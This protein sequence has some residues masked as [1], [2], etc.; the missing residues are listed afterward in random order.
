MHKSRIIPVLIDKIMILCYT[1]AMKND[2]NELWGEREINPF[3]K[4]NIQIVEADISTVRQWWKQMVTLFPYY[5]LYYITHGHARMFL[6]NDT[7]DLHPG[8]IYFIPAFSVVDAEC[9][10]ELEH[11]W[12]HFQL[13]IT[14]TS[15]LAVLKPQYSVPAL[16]SDEQ[17]FREII[18][19]VHAPDGHSVSSL[20]K[21]DGLCR[22]LLSRFLTTP[23]GAQDTTEAIRFLPV[24]R[25][26]DE[27]LSEPVC[28]ADLAGILYLSTTYFANLFTKQFGMS[29]RQYVLNKRMSAAATQ[30]MERDATVKEIAFSLGFDNESYFNRL[31]RKFTGM[32]PGAYRKQ[33]ASPPRDLPR[34]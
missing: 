18:N 20:V 1:I 25:Y 22:Y 14:T 34:P 15:Y 27:H 10:D 28:N 6:H 31:F 11:L 4:T 5:R 17:V 30:L 13:D 3:A 32:S 9:E 23:A 33:S 21:T 24:L 29:P 12:F 2:P 19:T 8:N 7:L 16:P 26:I